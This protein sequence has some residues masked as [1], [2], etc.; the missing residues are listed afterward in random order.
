MKNDELLVLGGVAAAAFF[1]LRKKEANAGG[2]SFVPPS[3][4]TDTEPPDLAA[5]VEEPK[6]GHL[7][8][9]EP[10][11]PGAYCGK[12]GHFVN[13]NLFPS[14][15]P[16]KFRRAV[17]AFEKLG[18][19]V[20]PGAYESEGAA[21]TWLGSDDGRNEVL[22]LQQRF[23]SKGYPAHG[24]GGAKLDGIAGACVLL[25]TEQAL[26]DLGAGSWP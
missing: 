11:K 13:G 25:D 26:I 8:R 6:P 21:A 19:S 24:A 10:F 14:T 18:A 1:L 2:P 16:A 4:P 9:I 17:E 15:D 12:A 3:P 20:W 7:K 23:R 5:P 22:N